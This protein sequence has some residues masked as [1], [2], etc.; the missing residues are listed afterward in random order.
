MAFVTTFCL[1]TLLSPAYIFWIVAVSPALSLWGAFRRRLIFSIF[2]RYFDIFEP[3]LAYIA[4]PGLY[5][6]GHSPT[7]LEFRLFSDCFW[8]EL[9]VGALFVALLLLSLSGLF[10]CRHIFYRIL[11]G[12]LAFWPPLT[13]IA[14]P[15]LY[16][17]KIINKDDQG[18][19]IP[20]EWP[21]AVPGRCVFFPILGGGGG[22]GR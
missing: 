16:S 8:F 13:Y 9:F 3:P 14:L 1:Y 22:A 18:E 7:S 4:L 15:G 11:R 20:Q 17:I 10:R 19:Q 21:G 12:I 2:L 5:F 6:L